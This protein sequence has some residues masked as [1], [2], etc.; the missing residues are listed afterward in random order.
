MR[1]TKCDHEQANRSLRSGVRAK[2]ED[3]FGLLCVTFAL[4]S[5][6]ITLNIYKSTIDRVLKQRT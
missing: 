5:W 4:T 1:P 6:Y 2:N 3:K